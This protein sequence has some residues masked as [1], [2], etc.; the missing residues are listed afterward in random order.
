VG[1]WVLLAALMSSCAGLEASRGAVE[2]DMANV[3]L[4][5]TAD[6]TLHIKE[7]RGRFLPVDRS[8]PYLDNKQSY[9][10][11]VDSGEI[12]IG[13][14]SLNALMARSMA[15]D[16][17]NV[18]HLKVSI[19]DGR[20]RQQ[21]V[22]DS[23]INVPFKASS[24][25]SA[26]ADGRIRVSTQSVRGFGVPLRPVMKLFGIEMDNLVKVKPGSGVETDG[27]DLIVDP[28]V[29][30]PGPSVRGRLTAVRIEGNRMVQTYGTT[31]RRTSAPRQLSPNHIYWRGSELSFGK[32]TMT[33]TDLELVD[34]DPRDAFDFS[35]DHWQAQLVAG[36]SKTLANR[37]LRAHMP[38]YNDLQ[39]KA[40]G[41]ECQRPSA[42]R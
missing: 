2:V 18:E 42:R 12:A 13:L 1:A 15:G 24:V 11:Y 21:G 30:I 3:D 8:V 36:Y 19:E 34:M 27:N 26:T 23:T 38:D 28:A 6:V 5:I 37:G 32:L 10:V 22:I 4:H 31:R 9:S 41:R 39:R 35:V 29:V 16:K 25:V 17:S 33:D 40:A 7:M 20:L 14:A